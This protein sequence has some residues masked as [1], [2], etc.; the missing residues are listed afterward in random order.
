[1][2]LW[3]GERVP[4]PQLS[5]ADAFLPSHLKP[6]GL[7]KVNPLWEPP[8]V[9]GPWAPPKGPSVEE[10]TQFGQ[11]RAHRWSP[12]SQTLL[13]ALPPADVLSRPEDRSQHLFYWNKGGMPCWGPW[14]PLSC[15]EVASGICREQICSHPLC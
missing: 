7:G 2:A 8:W 3:H 5:W 12:L 4:S 6:R 14:M 10:S 1:V 9:P 15:V 11:D 13:G